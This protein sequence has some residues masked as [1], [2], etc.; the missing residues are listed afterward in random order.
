MIRKYLYTLAFALTGSLATQAQDIRT[1]MRNELDTLC[2]NSFSGRGYVDSGMWKAAD[3][4]ASRFE[5]MRMKPVGDSWFQGFEYPANSFPGQLTLQ[6]NGRVLQPG[7]DYIVWP[8]SRNYAGSYD[9]DV[10]DSSVT[11]DSARLVQR[12]RSAFSNRKAALVYLPDS[13]GY[14][15]FH[16]K[17]FTDST[18]RGMI[19]VA[20]G[21]KLIWTPSKTIPKGLAAFTIK[22]SALPEKPENGSFLIQQKFMPSFMARNV[23]GMIP[24]KRTD[25]CIVLTA[26]YDHLGR[27]G[28]QALFPGAMDNASGTSMLL[29]LANYY[30]KHE[31]PCNIVFMLFAGEEAGLLGSKYYT[32]HPLF[33]LAQI[34][35]LLNIDMMGDASD[36]VAVIN[37][38]EIPSK[39]QLLKQLSDEKYQFKEVR[40]G[41][42]ASNSDHH[43]FYEKG[44]PAFFMFG[45]GGQG[46]YHDVYDK[47]E[48]IS[49]DNMDKVAD[50]IINFIDKL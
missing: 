21:K 47:P 14:L 4:L 44:V 39:Y 32:E 45:M 12:F 38:K 24:G 36:G 8:G 29:W 2:S 31:P 43:W 19:L 27:M 49:L 9:L 26:H 11:A 37:G 18:L 16:K 46:H 40:E 6:V 3:Y 41:G 35:F 10:I 5:G 15:P 13:V 34:K 7:V 30:S 25:S 48:T 20:T 1:F 42:K 28:R 33:P 17:Y 50:M 22:T 23:I